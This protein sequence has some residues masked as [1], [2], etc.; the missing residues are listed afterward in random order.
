MGSQ[1]PGEMNRVEVDGGTRIGFH[2]MPLIIMQVQQGAFF[3]GMNC[4][5]NAQQSFS[6]GNE[7]QFMVL[8]GPLP[9]L[10]AGKPWAVD[11]KAGIG[12]EIAFLEEKRATVH[13]FG[14]YHRFEQN[15][16]CFE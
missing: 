4:L 1:H 5:A 11:D 14:L 6:I 13:A 10:P 16:P 15:N 9:D 8:Y 3:Q 12:Y 7:Y 2:G